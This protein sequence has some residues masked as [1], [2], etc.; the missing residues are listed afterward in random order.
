MKREIPMEP[1]L[2]KGAEVAELL[3][4]SRALA[5]RWMAAGILPTV[6]VPGSRSIRVPRAALLEW[7]QANTTLPEARN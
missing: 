7:V 5:Y 2:L 3:G 4:T 6:K 1:L